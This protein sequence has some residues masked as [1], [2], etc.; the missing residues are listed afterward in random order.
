VKHQRDG[1]VRHQDMQPDDRGTPKEVTRSAVV[2]AVTHTWDWWSNLRLPTIYFPQ[3][4]PRLIRNGRDEPDWLA[5][6][7]MADTTY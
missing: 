6:I 5:I 3:V 1:E 4:W 2:N 7:V